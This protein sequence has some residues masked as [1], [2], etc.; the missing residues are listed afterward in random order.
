[1]KGEQQQCTAPVKGKVAYYTDWAIRIG[2]LILLVFKFC[3]LI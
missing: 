3:E 2:H 1:M